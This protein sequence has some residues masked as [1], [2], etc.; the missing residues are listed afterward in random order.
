MNI[1]SYKLPYRLIT[2]L[3]TTSL[4]S[5]TFISLLFTVMYSLFTGS[6]SYMPSAI[7]LF[8]AF[9][10]YFQ[11]MIEDLNYFRFSINGSKTK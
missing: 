8:V 7:L 1:V 4:T 5:M 6:Y 9:C 3:L 10:F 11:A 2:V